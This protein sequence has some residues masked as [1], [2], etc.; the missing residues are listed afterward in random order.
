MHEWTPREKYDKNHNFKG[1]IIPHEQPHNGLQ[2]CPPKCAFVP[3]PM[4]SHA[5]FTFH[6]SSCLP[7]LGASL[8]TV[9]I[10][11]VWIYSSLK[12]GRMTFIGRPECQCLGQPRLHYLLANRYLWAGPCYLWLM[13]QRVL[14]WVPRM[15]VCNLLC[16]DCS[17]QWPREFY[18]L[19]CSWCLRSRNK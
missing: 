11:E 17:I 3:I 13:L 4:S 18:A 16:L 6:S 8:S 5:H 9:F 7:F 19:H 10:L 2:N 14:T 15:T 12:I 1:G